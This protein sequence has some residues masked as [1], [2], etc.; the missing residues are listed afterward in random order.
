MK[1]MLLRYSLKKK[2]THMKI[3]VLFKAIKKKTESINFDL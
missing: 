1:T 2:W 3:V